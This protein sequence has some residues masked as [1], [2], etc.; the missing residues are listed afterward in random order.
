MNAVHLKNGRERSLLQKH[1]WIFSGAVER[2][3][4]EIAPG[5]LVRVLG[6]DGAY[7]AT[8]GY[9]PASQIAV[10]VWTFDEREEVDAVFFRSRLESALALRKRLFPSTGK[11]S[12]FRLVNGESDEIPGLIVDC[13]GSQLVCQFLAAGT[14]RW[15]DVIVG[16]LSR[17]LPD[18]AV[19][20]RSDVDVREKEGL[21]LRTGAI[22]G[23][24]PADLAE[25]REGDAR[26]H[27]DVKNGQKTGFYLDQRENRFR[28]REFASG[29]EVLNCFAYTGAFGI[30]ASLA[31][32]A[33]V[34]NI[35]SSAASLALA[36]RNFD[37]NGIA[38]SRYENIEGD[39]FTVLRSFRD[40]RRSFDVIV[41]DP[42]KF[43]DAKAALHGALRGYKD[44]NILAFKLLRPGGILFT[45][46]CSGLV[47]PE[48][49]AKVVAGAALDAG[50][51]AKI[52]GTLTQA[53]DHPVSLSFPEGAYLKGIICA[54]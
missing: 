28:F 10:R 37:L 4:G 8:G 1:P 44:I 53:A 11:S 42:P 51:K 18:H 46:S 2:I 52:I 21:S 49:F 14:E 29:R 23:P 20:E 24:E 13:Y 32:A 30:H 25:I 50:R 22:K 40:S 39:V 45:F 36:G 17:L 33:L 35:D 54:I 15:K 19:Y 48:L 27:V 3:E 34:T 43:A 26:F 41:L 38:S 5:D 16:E 31:G 12:A 47:T 6:A 7:L 9:S